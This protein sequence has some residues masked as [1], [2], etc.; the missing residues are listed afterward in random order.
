L[1]A[2]AAVARPQ[3]AVGC[4]DASFDKRRKP[5]L[6]GHPAHSFESALMCRQQRRTREQCSI[7][8]RFAVFG[9]SLHFVW[10]G[11]QGNPVIWLNI[12]FATPEVNLEHS[13]CWRQATRA[14]PEQQ[15]VT[16]RWCVGT[17][18]EGW[19]GA[20]PAFWSRFLHFQGG[21]CEDLRLR[22]RVQSAKTHLPRAGQS[23]DFLQDHC[24]K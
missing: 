18:L 22:G 13:I 23:G 19:P 4:V 5:L 16:R 14:G 1:S 9:R 6:R 17:H 10:R 24:D 8:A 3:L 7:L 21:S 2:S 20:K 11:L 15:S 12:P